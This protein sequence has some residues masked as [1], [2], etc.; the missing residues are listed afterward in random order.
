MH[1]ASEQRTSQKGGEGYFALVVEWRL[2]PELR[3]FPKRKSTDAPTERCDGGERT[4]GA[5][6]HKSQRSQASQVQVRVRTFRR[7]RQTAATT[8]PCQKRWKGAESR[9]GRLPSG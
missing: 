4:Y 7:H 9:S 1:A 5:L 2:S 3:S 8:S 6:S